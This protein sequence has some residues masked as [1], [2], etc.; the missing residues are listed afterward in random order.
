MERSRP[1]LFDLDLFEDVIFSSPQTP[2]P[3]KISL[4]ANLHLTHPKRKKRKRKNRRNL[5]KKILV[6]NK[7][8]W[9]VLE[10][11][12][13]TLLPLPKILDMSIIYIKK[14]FPY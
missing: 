11:V 1:I 3:T 5:K 12:E 4:C 13:A 2:P 10:L 9:H 7:R 8:V 14:R 6:K